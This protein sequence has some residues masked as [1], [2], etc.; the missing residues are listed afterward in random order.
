MRSSYCGL[1]SKSRELRSCPCGCLVELFQREWRPKCSGPNPVLS[2]FHSN[3]KSKQ[4][5]IN[6]GVNVPFN[7]LPRCGY[8]FAVTRGGLFRSLFGPRVHDATILL[9]LR[10]PH[11]RTRKIAAKWSTIRFTPSLF[12]YKVCCRELRSSSSERG[13]VAVS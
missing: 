1:R 4:E 11:S 7:W 10:Q 12:I 6:A 5:A 8:S 2:I 9:Y 3:E 13:L